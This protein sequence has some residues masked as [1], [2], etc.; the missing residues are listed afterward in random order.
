MTLPSSGIITL[1]DINGEFGL[2]HNLGAYR[3]AQWWKDDMSQGNFPTA[4]IAMSDFHAK[5][6]TSPAPVFQYLSSINIGMINANTDI[7]WSG[8]SIGTAHPLRRLMLFNINDYYPAT[9]SFSQTCR[10]DG[11]LISRQGAVPEGSSEISDAYLNYSG[12]ESL[13]L[14]NYVTAGASGNFVFRC[15]VKTYWSRVGL[16]TIYGSINSTPVKYPTTSTSV[17]LT[18]IEPGAICIAFGRYGTKNF[19]NATLLFT[20]PGGYGWPSGGY[21]GDNAIGVWQNLGSAPVNRTFSVDE[22][23]IEVWKFR[24]AA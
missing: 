7:P 16:A 9:S 3:G 11:T 15:N 24:M 22:G 21:N 18:G 5:R 4:P 19:T 14:S 10:L 6:A 13:W 12:R 23:R 2:G 8:V 20:Q 17:T 1:A